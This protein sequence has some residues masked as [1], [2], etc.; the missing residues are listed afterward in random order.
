MPL[1]E[2]SSPPRTQD[3]AGLNYSSSWSPR[4]ANVVIISP[5][6]DDETLGLGG[7]IAQF[8]KKFNI[9]ILLVTAGEAA[10]KN[11][12]DLREK[13]LNEITES[14]LV[15]GLQKEDLRFLNFPDGNCA[16]F[17]SEIADQILELIES[18]DT[19]ILAP[20]PDDGHPDHEAVS[21]ASQKAAFSRNAELKFYPIWAWHH[22]SFE[23]MQEKELLKIEF[24][25][26]SLELK[27]KAIAKFCTQIGS[28]Q[29]ILP[30]GVLKN[31]E[32]SWETLSS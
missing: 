23:K 26:Q 4:H 18:A 19:T 29:L 2:S 16:D 30:P 6:P 13:R 3:W 9:K 28:D 24:D 12:S 7:F 25:D 5:H 15:L 10:D 31:F 17:T 8:H 20:F 11:D 14:L 21:L 27:K 1:F 22:F 32:R